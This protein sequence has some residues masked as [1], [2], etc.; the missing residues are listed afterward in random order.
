MLRLGVRVLLLF[1][2]PF[3]VLLFVPIC[4]L[5]PALAYDDDV[6]SRRWTFE[7][8][9]DAQKWRLPAWKHLGILEN[10]LN[11]VALHNSHHVAVTS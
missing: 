8:S 1:I 5:F 6:N 2:S 10:V 11:S 7:C 4:M 3:C 9:V